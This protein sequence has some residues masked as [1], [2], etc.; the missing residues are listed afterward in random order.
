M[1]SALLIMDIQQGVVGRYGGDDS[2]LAALRT[3]IDGAHEAGVLVV[4]VRVA[5]RPGYPELPDGGGGSPIFAAIVKD[6]NDT[7]VLG[8]ATAGFHDALDPRPTDV[9]VLKKRI[10]AFAGSDLELVLRSRGI[11]DLVLTGIGTTGVVAFTLIEA[12]DRDYSLTVLSDGCADPDEE[13]HRFLIDRFFP[14][15]GKVMS[16]EEWVRSL[17]I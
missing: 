9:T 17:S 3:A 8:Q 4:F 16:A 15:Q 11:D 2:T 10:S 6:E 12:A 14:K 13:A 1:K 5:F 7:L